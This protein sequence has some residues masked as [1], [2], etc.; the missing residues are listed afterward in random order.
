MRLERAA[1]TLV[2]RD[3]LDRTT[4]DAISELAEVSPR[5]F[6]NYFESKDA[7]ILG[8]REVDGGEGDALPAGAL[9]D[10]DLIEAIVRLLLLT[11]DTGQSRGARR[12]RM[13][14][15]RRF[16]ELVGDLV[17]HMTKVVSSLS[18]PVRR[19]IDGDPRFASLGA[20]ERT[21]TAEL[22][23]SICGS[24]VRVAMRDW[25]KG[26]SFDDTTELE[27]GAVSLIRTTAQR[28]G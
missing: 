20:E 27:R 1:V 21:A 3:G 6:F 22:L 24:A 13:E 17:V 11:L 4:V 2:L 15:L 7:C 18:G 23:L 5:T 16:P 9:G 26:G 14:I 25:V 8:L 28:I 19:L 12:Q 10:L